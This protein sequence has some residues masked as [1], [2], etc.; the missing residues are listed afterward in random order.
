MLL[1]SPPTSTDSSL[2]P[3]T[4]APTPFSSR[5]WGRRGGKWMGRRL[6]RAHKP[7]CLAAGAPHDPSPA[8]AQCPQVS[9]PSLAATALTHLPGLQPRLQHWAFRYSLQTSSSN[10]NAA[11]I[12]LCRHDR[13]RSVQVF[14]TSLSPAAPRPPACQARPEPGHSPAGLSHQPGHQGQAHR[15][16]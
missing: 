2:A 15:D 12:R 5:A 8:Q 9:L 14:N 11:S 6:S 16:L 3:V 7:Y 1:C 13:N 10:S 4:S